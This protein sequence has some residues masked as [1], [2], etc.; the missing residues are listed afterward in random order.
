MAKIK[1]F[2]KKGHVA[3][4]IKADDACSNMMGDQKGRTIFFFLKLVMLHI[5]L[6]GIELRAPCKQICCALSTM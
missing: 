5:K 1:L 2:L 4:K 6:K 3:Y